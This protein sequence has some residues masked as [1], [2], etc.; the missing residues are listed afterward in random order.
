M[1]GI[2][3]IEVFVRAY[4]LYRGENSRAIRELLN[5][6]LLVFLDLLVDLIFN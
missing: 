3:N 6:T 1:A 4:K 2:L 5:G